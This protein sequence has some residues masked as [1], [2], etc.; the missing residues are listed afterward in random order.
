MSEIENGFKS[1]HYA[2]TKDGRTVHVKTVTDAGI[3]LG[4]DVNRADGMEINIKPEDIEHFADEVC[5]NIIVE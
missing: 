3:I 1:S 5:K 2:I 4:T